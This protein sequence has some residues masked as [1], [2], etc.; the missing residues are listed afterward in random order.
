[1]QPNGRQSIKALLRESVSELGQTERAAAERL[2]GATG[3]TQFRVLIVKEA[4][5]YRL[6]AQRLREQADLQPDHAI[7]EQF[8]KIADRYDELAEQVKAVLRR[9]D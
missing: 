8:R 4:E 5:K 1:M 6:A 7:S 3:I 9:A 2:A